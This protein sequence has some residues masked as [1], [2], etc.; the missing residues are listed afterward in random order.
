MSQS[1]D[2]LFV[3]AAGMADAVNY[4][5]WTYSLFAPLV[6]GAVL[7]VGCGVGTFTRRLLA[8]PA[9]ERLVS[10]DILEAA[11]R[12][13]QA[14]IVD[15]RLEL[16]HADVR[17]V[18]GAFDLVVCMNVLEHIEDDRSALAHM[19]RMIKPGGTLFLLVPAHQFLYND[20]DVAGGHFRRYGKRAMRDLVGRA[21]GGTPL[22][23]KQ[24]YFNTIGALGYWAVY[25]LLRKEPRGGAE[26]EIGWFD[27]MVV[28]IQRRLEGR[29]VPFGL[30]LVTVMTRPAA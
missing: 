4:A 27:R 11:V 14:T 13:C 30:S 2:D 17:D 24:F 1:A 23:V 5:D 18:D 21:A 22:T 3:S 20:F 15:P 19:L 28:P 7:E 9:L 25:T 12:Q 10:I 8:Q 16:R 29:A 26:S 6:R